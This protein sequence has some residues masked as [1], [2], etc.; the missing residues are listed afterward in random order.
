M[1]WPDC[2]SRAWRRRSA[3]AA[4]CYIPSTF[5]TAPGFTACPV[6]ADWIAAK[7]ERQ[8]VEIAARA[9]ERLAL[10]LDGDE[11]L[12]HRAGEAVVEPRALQLRP[13]HT[14]GGGQR[15]RLLAEVGPGAGEAALGAA[16]ESLVERTVLDRRVEDERCLAAIEGDQRLREQRRFRVLAGRAVARRIDAAYRARRSGSRGNRTSARRNRRR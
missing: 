2:E 14:L 6:C 11:K 7:T 12:A 5:L 15:H 9:V 1:K 16:D 8:A 10:F 3:R 13:R 4:A